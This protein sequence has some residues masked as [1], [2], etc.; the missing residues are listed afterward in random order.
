[1]I[2]SDGLWDLISPLQAVR[3]VGEHMSG[4]VTLS[5]FRLPKSEMRLK[6]VNQLL[7]QRKE[8]LKMKPLDTNAATHLIRNALG[9]TEYGIDHGKLSQLLMLPDDMVRVFRD[10]IT[11][12]VAYFDS[13]FLQKCPA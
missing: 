4:K 9:G 12:T 3:L 10:D 11:V 7:L 6:E 2:A 5:P 13:E 8:G 1:V